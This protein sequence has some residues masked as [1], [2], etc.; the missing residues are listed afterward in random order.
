MLA[1]FDEIYKKYSDGEKRLGYSSYEV[2]TLA[3]IVERE[4]KSASDFKKVASVFHNR[5]K[6]NDH[7]SYLQSCATVQYILGERKEVLSLSDTKIDSPYNTY[8][9]KGLPKGPIASPGE[10]AI[11]AVFNPENTDYL[12]FLNDN[13]GKLHFSRTLEEHN[14]KVQKYVN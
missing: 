4:G 3:S 11:L 1:R 7:L 8:K 13:S 12:Y 2:I 9:Y 14:L 6:R 5:L 10:A